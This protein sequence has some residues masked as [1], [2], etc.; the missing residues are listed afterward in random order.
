LKHEGFE[1]TLTPDN[2]VALIPHLANRRPKNHQLQREAI[3]A[4]KRREKDKIASGELEEDD[5]EGT[6]NMDDAAV[7]KAY[8]IR[9][10][11]PGESYVSQWQIYAFPYL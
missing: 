4:S 11:K 8:R 1:I 5:L 9:D 7:D 3:R 6:S 10:D 2:C